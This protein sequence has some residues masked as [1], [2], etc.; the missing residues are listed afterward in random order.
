MSTSKCLKTYHHNSRTS[1]LKFS[2]CQNHTSESFPEARASLVGEW[3]CFGNAGKGL[4]LSEI[5]SKEVLPLRLN[6][7]LDLISLDFKLDKMDL[8]KYLRAIYHPEVLQWGQYFLPTR[9][10]G[11]LEMFG[12][13]SYSIR[14]SLFL[15][16][17]RQRI[18]DVKCS[19]LG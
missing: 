11:K 1:V 5:Q 10:P 13:D 6:S 4:P 7:K 9:S 2:R 14:W 17:S 19:T 8:Q 3:D 16:S 18:K 12:D 15:S